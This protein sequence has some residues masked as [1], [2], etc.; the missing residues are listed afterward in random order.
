[1]L[2]RIYPLF[3]LKAFYISLVTLFAKEIIP[4]RKLV[5]GSVFTAEMAR[6]QSN[7]APTWTWRN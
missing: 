1:M 5:G 3:G 2:L 7:P 4:Y 6:T